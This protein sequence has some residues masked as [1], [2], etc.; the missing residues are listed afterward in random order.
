M[1]KL[2]VLLVDDEQE[3]VETLAARLM[4][5]D[6]EATTARNGEE[7]LSAVKQE[8]PDVILLDLKLPGIDGMEVLR[9][10][11]QAYPNVQVIMLTGHGSEQDEEAART[12]GAFDCLKKPV[13][14]DALVPRIKDAFKRKL[15]LLERMTMAAALAEAGDSDTARQMLRGEP[16]QEADP[17]D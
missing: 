5:R 12:L 16:P 14:I 11:K 3:F 1:P 15:Q 4:L 9:R 10:L 2:K 13:D 8:E 17:H 6:V 7:A